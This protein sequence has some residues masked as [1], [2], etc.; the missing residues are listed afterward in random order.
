MINLTAKDVQDFQ[1]FMRNEWLPI[2]KDDSPLDLEAVQTAVNQCYALENFKE[3]SDIVICS[4]PAAMT[5]VGAILENK[6]LVQ[7]IQAVGLDFIWNVLQG[8]QS[9]TTNKSFKNL[10]LNFILRSIHDGI[11][12]LKYT[13]KKGKFTLNSLVDSLKLRANELKSLSGY[14][15]HDAFWLGYYEYFRKFHPEP[16]ILQETEKLA[17]LLS[18]ARL[19]GWFLFFDKLAL[20]CERPTIHLDEQLNYSNTTGPA[21]LFKDNWAYFCVHNIEIE[22]DIILGLTPVTPDLIDSQPNQEVKR[23]LMELYGF[24]KYIETTGAELIDSSI[25]KSADSDGFVHDREIWLYK[26]DVKGSNPM[27]FVKVINS[28]PEPDGTFRTYTLQV[29]PQLEPMIDGPNRTIILGE[30]QKLTAL[31]AIASTFGKTGAEYQP[32]IET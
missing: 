27:M 14:G 11:E 28:S 7:H 13:P 16:E 10:D 17:G 32:D 18:Y 4:S 22:S 9:K 25:Y 23:I 29:S 5:L 26:K 15:N 30:P 2:L 3:P 19:A 8:I 21:I 12:K 6:E 1:N 31:N 20:V 24:D